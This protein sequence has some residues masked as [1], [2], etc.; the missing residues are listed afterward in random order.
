MFNLLNL[1]TDLGSSHHEDSIA[2]AW[3]QVYDP[4]PLFV[5]K[6]SSGFAKGFLIA[7]LRREN[8]RLGARR[9]DSP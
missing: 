8:G 7:S 3:A 1:K 4:K 9:L 6:G 5:L 2:M